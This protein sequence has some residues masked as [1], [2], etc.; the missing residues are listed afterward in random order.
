MQSLISVII[1]VYKVEEYLDRCVNSIT[2][3]IYKNLEIILVDDGSPDKCPQICDELAY[4]DNRIVV[5]HKPNGGLSDARNAGC[6]VATGEFISFIDSDD[7]IS[8]DFFETLL[9]VL[10]SENSDLVE[11]NLVKF[12]DNHRFEEYD[13]D[14]S[15]KN[16][17]AVDG[18]S[19][20]ISENPFHQHV[21]NKLYKSELTENIPFAFGK[22]N[23]D[24][25]WTYQIFGRAKKVTKLNKTMY[26]YFQ[27]DDSIMGES[28]SIKRL[29]ALEGKSN[30]QKYIE[31]YFPELSSQ[32]RIDF[33]GS[34]IFSYQSVLKFMNGT[35]KKEA[36]S[37]IKEYVKQ[38]K[39]N[40]AELNS[41]DGNNKYWFK[42]ADKSFL[43]CCKIRAVLGV[44][45]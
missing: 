23:E 12:Y 18:L 43:L 14:L 15:V 24:E 41:I 40:K 9:N 2:S 19:A 29:D 22:L 44:G 32:S 26:F 30:R 45:F 11:C 37:T 7:Y 8:N 13:D 38:C 31:K 4:T 5:I 3:Q 36:V 39:L 42:L 16:Y 25:F 6:R 20:L 1:P 10:E 34:C 17:S 21:W 33:F 35:E 27:R 28:F